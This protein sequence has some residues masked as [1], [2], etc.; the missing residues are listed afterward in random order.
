MRKLNFKILLMNSVFNTWKQTNYTKYEL[1]FVT[2]IIRIEALT[3]TFTPKCEKKCMKLYFWGWIY[4]P[5]K[6]CIGCSCK[7]TT[8]LENVSDNLFASQ[9]L[10]S[11]ITLFKNSMMPFSSIKITKVLQLTKTRNGEANGKHSKFN[12]LC[13]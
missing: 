1:L 4:L 12:C 11:F 5:I 10:Y 6:T 3:Y 7:Q 9:Y 8:K 2:F 13:I